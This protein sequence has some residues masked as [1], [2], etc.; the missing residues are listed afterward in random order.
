MLHFN[1]LMPG[2]RSSLS[3]A[4]QIGST[5]GLH[6]NFR[7]LGK[8]RMGEEVQVLRGR[9][10][11]GGARTAKQAGRFHSTERRA[12]RFKSSLAGASILASAVVVATFVAI[13]AR[14]VPEP[15][16]AVLHQ[17]EPSNSNR[18]IRPLRDKACDAEAQNVVTFSGVEVRVSRS[19]CNLQVAVVDAKGI[20]VKSRDVQVVEMHK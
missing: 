11:S 2:R 16:V 12:S 7:A 3:D 13:G 14:S 18:A 5:R 17:V 15:T 10:Q 9:Y 19:R 8:L 1:V 4:N 20:M 6:A